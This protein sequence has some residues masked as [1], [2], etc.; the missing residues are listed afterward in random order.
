MLRRAC[1]NLHSQ[2]S[3]A[4]KV[5]LPSVLQRNAIQMAVRWRAGGGPL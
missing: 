4:H 5:G 3:L 2:Y 1:A